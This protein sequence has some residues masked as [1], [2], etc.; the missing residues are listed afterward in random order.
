MVQTEIGHSSP[1]CILPSWLLFT[2][3]LF[4]QQTHGNCVEGVLV[5]GLEAGVDMTTTEEGVIMVSLGS[6]SGSL[7]SGSKVGAVRVSR[8]AT[9]NLALFPTS[10]KKKQ[11][12]LHCR[13]TLVVSKC[14][15]INPK[16][17]IFSPKRLSFT[18]TH[19]YVEI[20]QPSQNSRRTFSPLLWK[21]WYQITLTRK[22]REAAVFLCPIQADDGRD[23]Q[24]DK[25]PLWQCIFLV[26]IAQASSK[27]FLK[28]LITLLENHQKR[29]HQKIQLKL[30]LWQL[31]YIHNQQ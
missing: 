19:I 10:E 18:V 2:L 12:M 8:P 4:W 3:G 23:I 25:S 20:L 9:S 16:H 27:W 24:E 6:S 29:S 1:L 31:Q 28:G 17:H 13:V 21:P 15:P 26:K 5:V 11:K 14:S 30:L 22:W 7:G